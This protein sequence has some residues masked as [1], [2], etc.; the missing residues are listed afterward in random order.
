MNMKRIIFFIITFMTL[1][2]GQNLWAAETSFFDPATGMIIRAYTIEHSGKYTVEIEVVTTSNETSEDAKFECGTSTKANPAMIIQDA[3]S[4][5]ISMA[6]NASQRKAYVFYTLDNQIKL[7]SCELIVDDKILPTVSITSPTHNAAVSGNVTL[8]ANASDNIGVAGVQFKVNGNNMNSED[9]SAPYSVVWDSTKVPNGTYTITAVARDAANN[10]ATSAAVQ[11][12][13]SNN[14]VVA[15]PDLIV[16]TVTPP[17]GW[18]NNT[19]GNVF[20]AIQNIGSAAAGAFK[21]RGYFS[22]D[23]IPNNGGTPKDS[24]LFTWDVSGLAAG[25]TASRT[26]TCSFSGFPIHASYYVVV[27]VDSD[28]KVSESNESNNVKTYLV[29]VSR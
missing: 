14:P 17:R 27:K 15:M 21:V 22:V 24:L 5:D 12:T 8:S 2:F 13:V 10:S 26:F 29:N 4:P 28:N 16:T 25:Q 20:V 19:P 6:F 18:D 11:V 23:Q 3:D 7:A 1:I 9:T